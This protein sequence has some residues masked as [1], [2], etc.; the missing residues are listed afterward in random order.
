MGADPGRG[1]GMREGTDLAVL[2]SM[3]VTEGVPR[4]GEVLA[5]KYVLREHIGEGGMGVVY[6]ADQP[7]LA[8]AV[9]IKIMHPELA[10][11]AAL[12]RRFHNEAV[13]ACRVAHPGVVAIFDCGVTP[14][15]TPFIAMQ[16]VPGRLLGRVIAE[17][18][19]PLP[20][21]LELAGQILRTLEAVHAQ[22]VVHADVKSDN[23]LVERTADG[24]AITLIDFGLA[25][26]DDPWSSGGLVSGTPEY[27]A[28]ELVRGEPPTVASDLYGAGVIL[29]ELLTGLVPFEGHSTEEVL[30]RQLE[31]LPVAP[32]LR[33]PERDLPA[34]LDR[35]VLR[36]LVK[37]PR[38]R[39]ASAAELASALEAVPREPGA[40]ALPVPAEARPQPEARPQREAPTLDVRGAAQR[41]AH[42]T[43]HDLA[44]A[45][46]RAAIESAVGRADAP[47]IADGCAALA[48]TLVR[49]VQLDAAI[50][51]LEEGL[52]LIAASGPAGMAGATEASD[53]LTVALAALY[54]LAGQHRNA[55]RVLAATDRH[56]TIP[57]L[58]DHA[59]AHPSA[60]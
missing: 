39:F 6:L 15:G 16:H 17:D 45:Q 54:E 56:A 35:I 48:D 47:A 40:R 49:D 19:I 26:T 58:P 37:D 5:G 27:M 55:R 33:R 50:C 13:A 18:E 30:Q 36:A 9:A 51:V 1:P 57:E 8:R 4:T 25:R 60:A 46:L 59:P 34:V 3:A 14:Q 11:N 7:T 44:R 53:R 31:D 32:S 29:Y 38:A 20:R 2:G 21:A 43:E 52:A 22:G 41:A 28:P 23:I 12:V 10:A 42:S 24:E